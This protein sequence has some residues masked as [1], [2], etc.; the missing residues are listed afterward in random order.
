[1]YC[2]ECV[3]VLL[4]VLASVHTG[5]VFTRISNSHVYRRGVERLEI[6]DDRGGNI[7]YADD[8]D[9]ESV[10]EALDRDTTLTAYFNA[11]LVWYYSATL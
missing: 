7:V 6:H 5:P 11:M 3:H 1:M 2:S 8:M 4:R 9:G 10:Q